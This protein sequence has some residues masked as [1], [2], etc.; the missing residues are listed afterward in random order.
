MDIVFNCPHCRTELEVESSA[1]GETIPC[2]ACSRDIQI[3]SASAPAPVAP[4][5]SRPPASEPAKTF[6]VPVTNRPVQPLI[7]KALPPL[8][9]QA[10][11]EGR[12]QIRMKTLRRSDHKQAGH[13]H[14]DEVV[15]ELL[16]QI[17]EDNLVSISPIQYS[18]MELGTPIVDY[19]VI[20]VYRA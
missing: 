7:T 6:S 1:A 14:F 2:P 15:T 12:K 19:G 18:H 10:K 17:G 5:A 8:E 16:N 3:P 4:P 9:K 20:I 11:I 13:D